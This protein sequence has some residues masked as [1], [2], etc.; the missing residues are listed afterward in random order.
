MAGGAGEK[1]TMIHKII[2]FMVLFAFGVMTVSSST[3]GDMNAHIELVTPEDQ[4][5][6]GEIVEL[7]CVMEEYPEN[8]VITWQYLD[9]EAEYWQDMGIVGETCCFIL[10]EKNINYYYRVMITY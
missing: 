8:C 4:L 6:I 1:R 5:A 9:D 2:M 10:D 7:R 3:S